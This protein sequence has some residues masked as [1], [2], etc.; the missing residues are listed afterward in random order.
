MI[1]DVTKSSRSRSPPAPT[2]SHVDNK[3]S[4][5]TRLHQLLSSL[6][7]ATDKVKNW[8][9]S[10]DAQVHYD[11]ATDLIQSLHKVVRALKE[12]E[13]RALNGSSTSDPMSQSILDS[14]VALDL[15][16]L[17]DYGNGLN[18]EIFTKQLIREA[19]RQL[20]GLKRRKKALEML[21]QAI[22][23]G[24]KEME[25]NEQKEET[26]VVETNSKLEDAGRNK[27]PREEE[28]SEEPPAK[29]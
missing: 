25:L 10:Q 24:L 14:P 28:G 19:L 5:L 6:S 1:A 21:G 8:P 13:D 18:P 12:V 7:E 15:L 4:L 11:A 20:S 26:E 16:D 22:D 3:A 2:A 29:R 17:V 27:R 23:N 9:S